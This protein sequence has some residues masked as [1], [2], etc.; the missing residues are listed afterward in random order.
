LWT[1][2]VYISAYSLSIIFPGF[3]F[4]YAC[5]PLFWTCRSSYLYSSNGPVHPSNGIVNLKCVYMCTINIHFFIRI[6][7]EWLRHAAL[8][9]YNQLKIR[10]EASKRKF[11]GIHHMKSAG[12]TSF[13]NNWN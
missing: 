8:T 4:V 2:L 7:W 5:L 13:M 11:L 3:P 10:P 12:Q 6:I 1:Y 9:G